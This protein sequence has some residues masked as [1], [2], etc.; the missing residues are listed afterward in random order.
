MGYRHFSPTS[1]TGLRYLGNFPATGRDREPE[2]SLFETLSK[3]LKL[4]N[5][6]T[7]PFRFA[8]ARLL[9]PHRER[10][11]VPYCCKLIPDN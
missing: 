10:K 4:S 7:A 2:V 1:H 6:L 11:R 8:A 9:L 5:L 3:M